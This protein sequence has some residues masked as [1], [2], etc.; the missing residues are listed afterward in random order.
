MRACHVDFCAQV[1]EVDPH[2][3]RALHHQCL[4]SIG[5]FAAKG[6][7]H[8]IAHVKRGVDW[9]RPHLYL[10][11]A[12]WGHPGEG[13]GIVNPQTHGVAAL[14][15]V[16]AQPPANAEVAVV[17]DDATKNIPTQAG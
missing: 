3:W 9:P 17:V 10:V 4:N 1:F 6:F 5:E 7:H 8:H 16:G 2:G 14:R 12:L 13:A 15:E 11:T